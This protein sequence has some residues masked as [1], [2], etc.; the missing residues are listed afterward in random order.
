MRQGDN[1][2]HQDFVPFEIKTSLPLKVATIRPNAYSLIARST[3]KNFSGDPDH[4]ETPSSR[5][6]RNDSPDHHATR[7]HTL[8]WTERTAGGGAS[9]AKGRRRK[10]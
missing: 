8:A 1:V 3:A 5:A 4:H 2:T 10:V 6:A 9:R 7:K